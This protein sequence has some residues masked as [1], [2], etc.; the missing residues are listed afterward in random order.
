MIHTGHK[1][2]GRLGQN[3]QNTPAGPHDPAGWRDPQQPL[4]A[5]RP[6]GDEFAGLHNDTR[7]I[8]LAGQPASAG[9]VS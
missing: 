8:G 6:A 5:S 7:S 4:P 2:N 1:N 3:P 9:A